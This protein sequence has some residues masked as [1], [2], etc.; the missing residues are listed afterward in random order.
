MNV[1]GEYKSI[2]YV[3]RVNKK[4]LKSII[5]IFIVF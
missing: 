4:D 3:Q 1:I 2:S 5:K